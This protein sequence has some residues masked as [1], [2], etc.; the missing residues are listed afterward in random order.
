VIRQGS[1]EVGTYQCPDSS[2]V[3]ANVL[4]EMMNGRFSG[5]CCRSILR[6]EMFS[7]ETSVNAQDGNL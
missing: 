5:S 2:P 4:R 7:L 1:G 6:V 3:P